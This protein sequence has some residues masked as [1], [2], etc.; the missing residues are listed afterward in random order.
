M[1]PDDECSTCGN[2]PSIL[3]INTN[4]GHEERICAKCFKRTFMKVKE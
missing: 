2:I 1:N 3:W 4:N